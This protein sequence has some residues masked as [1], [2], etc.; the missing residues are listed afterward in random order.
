MT[1]PIDSNAKLRHYCKSV[2][3]GPE[4]REDKNKGGF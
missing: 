1:L 3:G 2:D 4:M